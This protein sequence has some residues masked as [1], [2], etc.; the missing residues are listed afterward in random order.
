MSA[1]NTTA[2]SAA[3]YDEGVRQTIPFYET[4]QQQAL[5]L[6]R[7]VKPEPA[8]WLD[9][10]CGTG[11]LVELAAPLFPRTH[12]IITDPSASM[13]EQARQRLTRSPKLRLDILPP[14]PTEKLG[15]LLLEKRPQVIT[16][17]LCH[18]YLQPAERQRAVQACFDLLDEDGLFV[19]FEIIEQTTPEGNAIGLKRWGNFQLEEGRSAAV[20]EAHLQRFRVDVLPIS[21]AAHVALLKSVGFRI[22]EHYWLSQMQAGFY[23]IK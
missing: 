15:A 13:L 4:I 3:A 20:V 18:H 23:A 2:H 14:L 8:R 17:L 11:Y 7:V 19:V 10:G 6:I 22:V 21:G 12:F 5:E 16:A 9:T 1:D